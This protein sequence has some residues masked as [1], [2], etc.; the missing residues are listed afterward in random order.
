MAWTDPVNVNAGEIP[1]ASW[2][3]Q[4]LLDN[5]RFLEA[6][7]PTRATMWHD[8]CLVTAGNAISTAVDTAHV[9]NAQ[10]FQSAAANGDTFTNGFFLKAGTYTFSALGITSTDRGLIDWYIDNVKVVSL[11][12]WYAAATTRNVIKTASVTVTGDGYH[13][14]KGVVNG[15]NAASTSFIMVLTKYWFKSATD[16]ENHT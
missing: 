16:T 13:V 11:Q 12:D 2:V 8:E 9:Y 6:R 7:M 4:Y 5:L 14:L 15:K 10:F 1:A 3:N